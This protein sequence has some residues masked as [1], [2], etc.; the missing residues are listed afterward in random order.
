MLFKSFFII[1]VLLEIWELSLFKIY[2]NSTLK[3]FPY[4][5][6]S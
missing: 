3:E 1:I 4:H 6:E 5:S 2:Q